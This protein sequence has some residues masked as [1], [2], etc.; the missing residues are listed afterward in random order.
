MFLQQA[1]LASRNQTV[2]PITD[3]SHA[4]TDGPV[5]GTVPGEKNAIAQRVI[6]LLD[7]LGRLTRELQFADGL[8]PAQ[9]EAL[10]FLAQANRYSRS[11]TALADYLGATKGTV[12]QT[13]IA[14]ESKGLIT[15]CKKTEDRRQVDLCLTEAG[16][17]MLAKDPMQTLEQA[18][19]E[20]ADELGAE[21]VKGLSR[22]L[23][24]LQTRNQINEFGVCQ[25]CSLFCVN[26]QA[27]L[28]D[29]NA[30]VG[31]GT[32][33]NTGETVDAAEKTKICVNYKTA[34]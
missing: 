3:L 26:S 20:I 12:S 1:V 29:M 5:S 6:V 4:V 22:L 28:V 18:T 16:Q 33:G 34:N 21:M 17:A 27:A 9:W 10:R 23:H 8:N 19:L 7:R 13:L 31:V 25:D 15:R 14:L 30:K 11:P 2:M 32:C 24:D